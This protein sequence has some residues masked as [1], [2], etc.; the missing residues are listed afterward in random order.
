[1]YQEIRAAHMLFAATSLGLFV[2]RGG[3]TLWLERQPASRLLKVVPHAIDSLLLIC[4]VWLAALLRLDPLRTPW[5]G[6]KLLCVLAYILL[7]ILAFRLRGPRSLKL[8]L[9]AAAIL[10]FGF[11]VS[12]ALTHDPLGIFALLG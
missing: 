7:G 8:S 2:L 3:A 12:I 5:L 4:G 9:F 11:I 6:V 10:M 1:M